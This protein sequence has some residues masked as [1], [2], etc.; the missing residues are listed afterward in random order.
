MDAATSGDIDSIE[1]VRIGN[2]ISSGSSSD[3]KL[4][5]GDLMVGATEGIRITLLMASDSEPNLNDDKVG[6]LNSEGMS[7]SSEK[8]VS[9]V[10]YTDSRENDLGD[11][12]G[13]KALR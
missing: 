7:P 10:I 13:S 2:G 5:V 9:A 12:T 4:I 8:N 11:L 6:V 1:G 3:I